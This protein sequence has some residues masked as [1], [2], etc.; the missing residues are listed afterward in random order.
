MTS[1][2]IRP[3]LDIGL[4]K[5]DHIV[6]RWTHAINSYKRYYVIVRFK[7]RKYDKQKSKCFPFKNIIQY[8]PQNSA[9]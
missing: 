3:L 5:D 8:F 6:V 1:T 4:L 9:K 7:A 2:E